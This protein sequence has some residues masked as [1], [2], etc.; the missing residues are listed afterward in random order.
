MPR[1]LLPAMLLLTA[2][3]ASVAPAAPER[4]P[5]PATGTLILDAAAATRL[6]AARGVTLQWISW[7]YRGSLSVWEEGGTIRLRGSQDAAEGQGRLEL[8]GEVREVGADYFVFDG[9]IAIADTP[10]P[11]RRCEADKT[12]HFAETQNR[13]YWRLREFEWCDDLTDYIDVYF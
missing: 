13:P 9:R 8:D 10:D 6:L 12:W 5:V 11:G 4:P 1:L 3:T 7:D 2:C